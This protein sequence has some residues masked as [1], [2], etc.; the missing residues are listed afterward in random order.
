MYDN[1]FVMVGVG[2]GSLVGGYVAESYTSSKK[3]YN[4]III[5]SDKGLSFAANNRDKEG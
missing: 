2:S 3:W 5:R 4:C 1:R